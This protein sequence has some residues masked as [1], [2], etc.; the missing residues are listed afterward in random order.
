MAGLDYFVGIDKGVRLTEIVALIRVK[1]VFVFGVE[2]CDDSIFYDDTVPGDTDD[3]LN[4]DAGGIFGEM[5]YDNLTAR[6]NVL[7]IL[8]ERALDGGL[9]IAD[10]RN[11]EVI[12][13]AEVWHH[14]GAD[15]VVSLEHKIVQY[16]YNG[17]REDYPRE[18]RSKNSG[19]AM[20]YSGNDS[21][22]LGGGLGVRGGVSEQLS[23][24][25][26]LLLDGRL[27]GGSRRWRLRRVGGAERRF[28]QAG[29]AGI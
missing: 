29:L 1:T 14:A 8:T 12:G 28:G 6:G 25:G 3:P 21:T 26:R 17:N 18:D 19:K 27:I 2:D 10:F 13:V 9:G 24:V 7:H 15:D 20:G 22:S 16:E 5:E 11:D 4:E 23:K